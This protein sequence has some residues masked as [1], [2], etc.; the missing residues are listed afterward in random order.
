MPYKAL[1]YFFNAIRYLEHQTPFYCSKIFAI[2]QIFRPFLYYHNANLQESS[3]QG[4][5]KE[6]YAVY[7]VREPVR[8][9]LSVTLNFWKY[10]FENPYDMT[11]IKCLKSAKYVLV[12]QED[13][14]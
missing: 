1:N 13:N 5:I 6:I 4:K 2:C 11:S 14:R 9:N 7:M 3:I 8:K 10:T 12:K